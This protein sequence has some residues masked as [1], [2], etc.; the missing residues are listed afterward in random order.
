MKASELGGN[1]ASML[2][3]HS[4]YMGKGTGMMKLKPCPFCGGKP[5]LH[6]WAS[7]KMSWIGCQNCGM[8]SL[9][10]RVRDLVI[11]LWNRRVKPKKKEHKNER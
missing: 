4:R 2:I 10:D 5:T 9:E 7:N 11:A 3:L 8:G 1:V 6:C